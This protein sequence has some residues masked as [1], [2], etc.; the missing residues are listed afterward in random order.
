M[1][2]EP[3]LPLGA[4]GPLIGL[5]IQLPCHSHPPIAQS[6]VVVVST[7]VSHSVQQGLGLELVS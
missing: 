6:L 5:W 2:L 4:L 3:G 1:P 7:D